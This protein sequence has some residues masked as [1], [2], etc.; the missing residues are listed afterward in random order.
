MLAISLLRNIISEVQENEE[1]MTAF[2]EEYDLICPLVNKKVEMCNVCEEGEPQSIT[3][4]V[5]SLLPMSADGDIQVWDDD[6]TDKT[7]YVFFARFLPEPLFHRLLSRA[8][9]N[10]KLECLNSPMVLYRDA[11]KFW[12]SPWQPYRIKL[13]KEQKMIEVTFSCR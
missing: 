2:L 7:F 6:D 3:H 10:S 9:K 4:F 1:A 13:M 8:H 11:G 5:P 12:M